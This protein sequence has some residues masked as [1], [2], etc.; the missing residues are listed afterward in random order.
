[1]FFLT[2]AVRPLQSANSF[3]FVEVCRK[4]GSW[5]AIRFARSAARWKNPLGNYGQTG[6]PENSGSRAFRNGGRKDW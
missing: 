1:M 3:T 4:I 5:G 6:K 2:L